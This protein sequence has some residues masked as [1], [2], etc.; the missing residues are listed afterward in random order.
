MKQHNLP[1]E[2]HTDDDDCPEG[3]PIMDVTGE[4]GIVIHQPQEDD[5]DGHGD[6]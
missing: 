1:A 3:E 4:G 6:D 2:T 5:G